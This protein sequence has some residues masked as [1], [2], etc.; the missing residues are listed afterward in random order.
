MDYDELLARC[1][2]EIEKHLLD[3]LYPNLG[4]NAQKEIQVQ[5]MIDYY[6]MPATLPDF[7]FPDLRIA[8][9]CDGYTYRTATRSRRT[10]SSRGTY[11]C[12]TG[13]SCG[14]P[15]QRY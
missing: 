7:A 10:G 3:A 4:P 2:S 15:G 14:S 6:A 1:E 13:W 8:I 9:Y 12:K 11:S 5:H